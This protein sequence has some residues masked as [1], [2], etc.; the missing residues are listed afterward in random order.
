MVSFINLA[1]SKDN[2]LFRT[3]DIRPCFNVKTIEDSILLKE[4][5]CGFQNLITKIF[6][7]YLEIF[8]GGN[9]PWTLD[10]QL[11]F[12]K[13]ACEYYN[14]NDLRRYEVYKSSNIFSK[15][16]LSLEDFEF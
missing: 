6:D 9:N 1:R 10:N 12:F 5:W 2:D 3:K 8:K 4:R 14:F 13:I 16:F 15:G 7:F 11:Q